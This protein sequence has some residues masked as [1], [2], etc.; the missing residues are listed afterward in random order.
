MNTGQL[1]IPICP[2]TV[3]RLEFKYFAES[4]CEPVEEAFFGLA[5]ADSLNPVP[6]LAEGTF[7]LIDI[8]A[9]ISPFF[10]IRRETS[11]RGMHEVWI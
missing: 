8:E 11:Q 3:P 2:Q 10:A 5:S 7:D 9:I 4:E 1:F 6:N